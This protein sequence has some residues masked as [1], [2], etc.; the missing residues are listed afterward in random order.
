MAFA[1]RAF[2]ESDLMNNPAVLGEQAVNAGCRP[3]E[4]HGGSQRKA[5]TSSSQE[6]LPLHVSA[7]AVIGGAL[8]GWA[9]PI[10]LAVAS[11]R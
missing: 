7:G 10:A 5:G 9:V 3:H 11:L 8:I 2:N 4:T 6:K 1:S